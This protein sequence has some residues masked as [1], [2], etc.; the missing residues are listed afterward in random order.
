MP[1]SGDITV[2][3][4]RLT[5][6]DSAAENELLPCV[7]QELKKLAKSHLRHER[8]GHTLQ[9]TALVH[10][11]WM[12][13]AGCTDVDFEDRV[14][15]FRL[16]AKVMR[17]V[18]VDHARHSNAKKRGD[19]CVPVAFDESLVVSE[20]RLETILMVDEALERFEKMDPRS[21]QVVVMRYFSGMTEEEIALAL[22]VSIRTVKRDWEI[23][24]AWL[25]AELTDRRARTTTSRA[26]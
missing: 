16:S 1:S 22:Q 24:R 3:L 6:G 23:A 5:S 8:A 7:Y 15:F 25:L 12:R 20:D 2:L 26:S 9:T 4:R 14:H 18:L 10:E 21:A 13:M 17:R 19:G 11:A